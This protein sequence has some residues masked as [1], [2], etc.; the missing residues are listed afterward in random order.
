MRTKKAQAAFEYLMIISIALII[1]MGLVSIS[2]QWTIQS[3]QSLGISTA[4]NSVGKIVEAADL[5]YAQGPPAKTRILIQV[6][7]RIDSVSMEGSALT[8]TLRAGVNATTDIT[9]SS[10]AP[11]VGSIPAEK[12]TYWIVVQAVGG[13]VN[14]TEQ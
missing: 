9:A 11:L 12:G 7:E 14:V 2:Y 6:P 3:K 5:V 1:L 13:Q 10:K 4:E 8:F